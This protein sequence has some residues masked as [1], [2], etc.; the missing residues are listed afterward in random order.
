MSEKTCCTCPET[1]AMASVPMQ[2]WCELYDWD[3]ALKEGTIFTCLNLPIYFAD[4]GSS[5]LETSSSAPGPVQH[6]R[7]NLM[8]RIE[9]ISFAINDL[10]LYLDTHPCC[11]DG[12][13]LFYQLSKE[14][15][16][17]LAEYASKYNPLTQLSMVTA[18]LSQNDYAWADGPMPWEGGCI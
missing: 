3:T 6:E 1:L 10:T 15:M 2:E 7:E 4:K 16:D 12:T 8:G 18:G 14:R 11:P 17:L 9:A 13:P 5:T